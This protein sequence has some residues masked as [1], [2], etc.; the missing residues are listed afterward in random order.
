[1][2]IEQIEQCNKMISVIKS[3]K[4]FL[5]FCGNK[6][7]DPVF[8]KRPFRLAVFFKQNKKGNKKRPLSGFALVKEDRIG[9]IAENTFELP[10]E[11]QQR[12]IEVAE[13]YVDEVIAKVEAVG[14]TEDE[15]DS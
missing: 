1:M 15:K 2:K 13:Q 9:S 8:H 7:R 5:A 4:D 14:E 3:V 11:L 10:W 6:Y 12:I